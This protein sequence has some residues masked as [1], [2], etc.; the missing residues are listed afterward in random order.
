MTSTLYE[1]VLETLK[2]GRS[3]RIEKDFFDNILFEI[4]G[5]DKLCIKYKHAFIMT[6]ETMDEKN[7]SMYFEQTNQIIDQNTK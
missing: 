6:E 5:T 3:I 7:V 2:K 4:T 1:V